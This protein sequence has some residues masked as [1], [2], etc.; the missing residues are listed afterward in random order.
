MCVQPL[1]RFSHVHILARKAPASI[2]V[3]VAPPSDGEWGF[4]GKKHCT[5][6]LSYWLCI[7]A[8]T[9]KEV[10][11]FLNKACRYFCINCK[12]TNGFIFYICCY[13]A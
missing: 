6:Q 4:S 11:W 10:L 2:H 5:F 3:T 9:L 8:R 7:P 13:K 1:L 12:N